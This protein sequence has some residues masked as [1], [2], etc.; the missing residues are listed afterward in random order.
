MPSPESIIPSSQPAQRAIA[1][2]FKPSVPEAEFLK[3]FPLPYKVQAIDIYEAGKQGWVTDRTYWRFL[4]PFHYV[5][6]T[7]GAIE[8][9]GGFVTD[10]ASVPPKLH[11]FIDDDSPIILYPS[12]P[13][14]FLFTRHKD[15]TRGWLPN[16][17]RLSLTDVNHVLTEAMSFCGANAFTRDLVFA[18][19]ELA[20]ESIRGEFA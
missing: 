8:V 19:V 5:S 3:R 18:A 20:N 17:K 6:P 13:H 10:F 7:W 15:G 12:A 11:S 1:A 16:G 9:P 14:D 4:D 2:K